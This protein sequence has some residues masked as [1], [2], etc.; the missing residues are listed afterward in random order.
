MPGNVIPGASVWE[1]SVYDHV[2]RHTDSEREILQAYD[3]LA[4]ETSS[5]AFAYLAGI[6]LDDERRHHQML[7]D[8][9]ETIRVSAELSGE[10]TPIPDLGSFKADRQAILEA[11]Q[12]F[13]AVEE[14]DNEDLERLA[15]ELKDTRNTTLWQLVVRLI[16]H[17]NE[18]HRRIL[19]F[20]R[21]R[22]REG[23]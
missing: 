22:A 4:R 17:D 18:K 15:R 12:R 8:L 1:Q 6:I 11:T 3:E 16:Q 14:G 7:R 23:A 2:T 10:P 19:G 13:L 21:D 5:P 9:A 20:I